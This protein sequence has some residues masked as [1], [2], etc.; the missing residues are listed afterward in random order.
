MENVNKYF[1]ESKN[2]HFRQS[3]SKITV[4]GYTLAI[5]QR[6]QMNLYAMHHDPKHWNEP[7]KFK[8]ERFL[9]NDN[10]VKL[11]EW[12]QPFGYG[13]CYCYSTGQK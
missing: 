2:F 4:A 1:S 9:D 5:G 11:D 13:E 3:T 12:L 8:P 6:V 7:E 10:M